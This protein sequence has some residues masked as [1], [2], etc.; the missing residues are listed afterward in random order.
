MA[1]FTINPCKA[2]IEKLK[3]NECDVNSINDCCYSTLD[4]FIGNGSVNSIRNTQQA[5][6]CIECVKQS[7]NLIGRD[8]C[9]MKISPPAL[10]NQTP[11][12]FPHLLNETN[13]PNISLEECKKRCLNSSFK[14]ECL[15]NCITDFNAVEI[16]NKQ[17]K[18]QDINQQQNQ[19]VKQQKNLLY[20]ITF[21][22]LLILYLYIL[23]SIYKNLI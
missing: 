12:Y 6:N 13:D 21:I 4:A 19:N 15:E 3:N 20:W 22:I 18:E 23:Y 14:N 9:D 17:Q 10:F 11:H 5:K 2:C 8:S 1:D 16:F 7:I